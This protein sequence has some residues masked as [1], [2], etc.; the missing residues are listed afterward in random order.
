[1][2][3]PPRRQLSPHWSSFHRITMNLDI[4]GK[5]ALV[6]GSTAGIGYAIAEALAR[7][8]AKVIVNGRT[9]K[10]VENALKQIRSA[11]PQAKLEGLPAD[12]GSAE[13]VGAAVQKFPEVDILIN[14]VGI[15]E[16]KAFEQIPDE[17]WFRLFEV[18]VMSGIRLSRAY[19]AGMKRQNWGRIIF[20]SSESAVQIPTEMI[21]Y[22][23][24]KTA[25]L[26]VSRGL[27][28][29]TAGTG[30]TVNSVLAGPTSSKEPASLSPERP[31]RRAKRSRNL[32]PNSSAPCGPVLC[33]SAS[34]ARTRSR[35]WWHSCAVRYLLRR[36]ARL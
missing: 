1:M 31:L 21:H 14:N 7:E 9:G 20:I 12:L 36:M 6:T 26:A 25:Q 22:G 29:I 35:H 28:E 15:F 27:A 11:A 16:I 30:V 19:L 24:T 8:G 33:C 18:N 32:R 5:L 17:D 23:M 2:L 34:R 3:L 10:R 4:N 13:G